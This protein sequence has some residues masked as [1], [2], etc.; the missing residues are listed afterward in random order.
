MK[1]WRRNLK[2]LPPL[3]ITAVS[4][5]WMMKLHHWNDCEQTVKI[6]ERGLMAQGWTLKS[7][8]KP[9]IEPFHVMHAL[10]WSHGQKWAEVR[11]R[12]KNNVVHTS[13]HQWRR[14]TRLTGLVSRWTMSRFLTMSAFM[15][16]L[17]ISCSLCNGTQ[18]LHAVDV[19]SSVMELGSHFGIS[20]W[21]LHRQAR[22][23]P[24]KLTF[25]PVILIVSR[26][27]LSSMWT[28]LFDPSLSKDHGFKTMSSTGR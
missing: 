23:G 19:W 3:I 17:S 8:V 6:L 20:K 14:T 13:R 9:S 1:W 5:I 12:S 15:A 27:S 4:I 24:F 18:F 26:V 10:P 7:S 22:G 11:R 2:R 25:S 16:W 21:C 28:N